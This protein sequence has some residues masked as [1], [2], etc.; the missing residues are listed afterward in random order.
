MAAPVVPGSTK[1]G[2]EDLFFQAE[3]A[4]VGQGDDGKGE[5]RVDLAGYEHGAEIQDQE[6][7]VH[8]VADVQVGT[9]A[10]QLMAGGDADF[11][12]PVRAEDAAG[13]NGE[14]DASRF[15]DE[16]KCGEDRGWRQEAAGQAWDGKNKEYHAEV[17]DDEMK[18][19][20]PTGL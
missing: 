15:D 9:R 5:E 6:A 4:D 13:P 20:G 8:R 11:T 16:A 17:E 19:A 10:D 2:A 14:C 1:G 12:A 7:R 18:A 3:F